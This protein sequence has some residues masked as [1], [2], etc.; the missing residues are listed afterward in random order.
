MNP[1]W[2]ARALLTMLLPLFACR[3]SERAPAGVEPVVVAPTAAP[4]APAPGPESD[5]GP[6]LATTSPT[7]STAPACSL[8][9]PIQRPRPPRQVQQIDGIYVYGSVP[10]VEEEAC[11]EAPAEILALAHRTVEAVSEGPPV[12]LRL[13]CG[14]AAGWLL[15]AHFAPKP[16]FRAGSPVPNCQP[17]HDPSCETRVAA[18]WQLPTTG[19]PRLVPRATTIEDPVDVDGDGQAEGIAT[20]ARDTTVWFAD[21][22]SVTGEV[23]GAW[24]PVGMGR[25][26]VEN[27]SEGGFLRS[28]A[29][30]FSVSRRGFV[31]APE[32][33]QAAWESTYAARC[34][35]EPVAPV[36]PEAAELSAEWASEVARPCPVLT[37][38]MRAPATEPILAAI[39]AESRE[40]GRQ[41]TDGPPHFSWGCE[42][43]RL[44]V[45]V[46]YCLGYTAQDCAEERGT[47][48]QEL[49]IRSPQGMARATRIE[50]GSVLLEW[51]VTRRQRLIAHADLDGDGA[52]DPIFETR[53]REGGATQELVGYH[54][55]ARGRALAF[56]S[57]VVS[58]SLETEVF[59]VR[60]GGTSRDLLAVSHQ[61]PPDGEATGEGQGTTVWE[62]GARALTRHRGA[63]VTLAKRELSK[64]RAAP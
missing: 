33:V 13:G 61:A 17:E 39:L 6:T 21:G 53:E 34:P 52:L 36:P 30:A 8:G 31:E 26:L 50:S 19:R 42:Q 14:T 27:G 48:R 57:Q 51:A 7:P 35:R 2:P 5:A 18:L 20:G 11:R 63:G 32:L 15:V 12:G 45:L 23:T 43:P 4:M 25:V 3:S 16:G 44:S 62:L 10:G 64:R 38:E 9:N 59:A 37:D 46:T 60:P 41:V 1:P 29:R 56:S 40:T 49:W 22:A 28:Q 58:T 24:L 47:W 54:A 55:V